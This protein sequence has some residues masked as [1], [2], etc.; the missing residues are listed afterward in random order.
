MNM[1]EETKRTQWMML[2]CPFCQK[3]MIINNQRPTANKVTGQQYIKTQYVCPPC[4]TWQSIEVPRKIAETI[5]DASC[6]PVL[7][8][9]H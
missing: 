3:R 2:D 6:L 9:A 4:D 7:E 5:V 1:E 8:P